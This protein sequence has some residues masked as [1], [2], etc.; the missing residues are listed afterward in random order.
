MK[1]VIR[2]TTGLAPNSNEDTSEPC[3]KLREAQQ[4]VI[5]MIMYT[6]RRSITIDLKGHL[7]IRIN[8]EVHHT[9]QSLL[10]YLIRF[11]RSFSLYLRER[12]LKSLYFTLA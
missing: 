9:R 12:A 6:Y 1:C 4:P 2:I 11:C 3:A 10:S 5:I 8:V 7:S